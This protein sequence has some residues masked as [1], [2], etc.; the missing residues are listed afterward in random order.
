MQFMLD[1]LKDIARDEASLKAFLSVQRQ[2]VL[3]LVG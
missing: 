2:E 1:H 3:L